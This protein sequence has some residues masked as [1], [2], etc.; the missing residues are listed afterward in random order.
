MSK[1]LNSSLQYTKGVG[2]KRAQ[3]FHRLGVNSVE[4]LLYYFPRRYQD[5]RQLVTIAQLSQG[6]QQ[7]FE[8]E[9]IAVSQRQSWRRRRFQIFEAVVSDATG[10]IKCVW[11]NQPYLKNYFK[12]GQKVVLYGKVEQYQ[13]KLQL[14]AAEFELV[15]EGE[16]QAAAGQGLIPIYTLPE[17]MTQR[18]FRQ[19]MVK[20]LDEHIPQ[21]SECLPYDL[22][23]K[24]DLLNLA[25]SLRT[26][27]FPE[28]PLAHT[29]AYTR[30]SFEEFFIFQLP[31]ALRK[32][33]R[34]TIPG[35]AHQVEVAAVKEFIKS[36]PF[37]LT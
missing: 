11:F 32:A 7:G 33:H 4:D 25:K 35:I 16:T 29:Q 30:L 21:I 2:P 13:G 36:L 3:A 8:A 20:V 15:D 37:T 28:S 14:S 10:R 34:K 27:H 22:R 26:I 6:Q 1:D 9:V 17:G 24:Y 5:R 12:P 31:L 18:T 19:L 23:V